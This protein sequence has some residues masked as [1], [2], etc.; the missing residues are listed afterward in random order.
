[1]VKYNKEA[2]ELSDIK[3]IS[4]ILDNFCIGD[5]IS[6]KNG[7]RSCPAMKENEDDR[8]I[9]KVVSIPS[10]QR[11][12]E[13]LLLAGAYPD[14]EAANKYFLEQAQSVISELET[15]NSFTEQDG[16]IPVRQWQLQPM[17]EEE[18]GY[19]VYILTDYG[20]TLKRQFYKEPLTHLNAVNLGIDLCAAL[21]ACRNAGYLYVDLKPTN[22]LV[23][24]GKSFKIGDLGFIKL[25]NIAYASLPERYR[26]AYTAPEVADA[27]SALSANMDVYALGLVLYQ[28]YNNG[29]L[30][31]SDE[32][33]PAQTFE[34]PK[35]ADEEMAEI[36]L[37]ACDPDPA[38]RW[39]D[40]A[41]M[42][43]ALV[44]YMQRVGAND[45]P[46]APAIVAP[47]PVIEE[48]ADTD[49]ALAE[50]AVAADNGEEALISNSE[51]AP[52]QENDFTEELQ[53]S[54]AQLA[55]NDTANNDVDLSVDELIGMID[56]SDNTLP[57]SPETTS[58]AEEIETQITGEDAE[59]SDTPVQA[60]ERFENAEVS[61]EIKSDEE[62]TEADSS[63][64]TMIF[65]ATD[66]DPIPQA[67]EEKQVDDAPRPK[68]KHR[69]IGLL[70]TIVILLGL[71]AGAYCGYKFYYIKTVESIT[72]EGKLDT[73]TVT[74]ETDADPS[75][76]TVYCVGNGSRI[77]A[78]LVNGKATFT[79][80]NPDQR[81]LVELEISGLHGLK[82]KTSATYYTPDQISLADLQI[83][84]GDIDGSANLTFNT[85][86][87]Y[88]GQWKVEYV[89]E[90]EDVQSVNPDSTEIMLK[91]LTIGKTYEITIIPVTGNNWVS[92]N[93][94]TF[95]AQP[96][97]RAQDITVVEYNNGVLNL[98]WSCTEDVASWTVRC[99]NNT[100]YNKTVTVSKLAASFDG[101][102]PSQD[103]TIEVNAEGQSQS[104]TLHLTD[105]ILMVE[106]FT[107]QIVENNF[108]ELNWTC[109]KDIP[110]G[111]WIIE[112]KFSDSQ[113]TYKIDNI[114]ENTCTL[115]D[116]IPGA[117]YEFTIKAAGDAYV[118]A[119]N[120]QVTAPEAEDYVNEYGGTPFGKANI[121][122]KMCVQ[123]TDGIWNTNNLKFTTTFK[124]GE[125][126]GFTTEALAYYNETVDTNVY[127]LYVIR[128]ES[129]KLIMINGQEVTWKSL[130]NEYHGTLSVPA[131][132]ENTGK[133]TLDIY[134]NGGHVTTQAFEIAE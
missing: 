1:M 70:L 34:A 130:F 106:N 7:V 104:E 80:L 123:P 23:T 74:V 119:S 86:K 43:Q 115:K 30:P 46:I 105:T 66:K 116:V 13:A 33:A 47:A 79:N 88:S 114:S 17:D 132:P 78:E 93:T 75:L 110:T 121:R 85:K 108:I 82:G 58:V 2:I 20:R 127:I 39:Q 36:I 68:R 134:Y 87:P 31:F 42:G 89:T 11:K 45:T 14:A 69:W 101:L 97:I 100:D 55:G 124:A 133:Y 94:L 12:L 83:Q 61:E 3:L 10:S 38:N 37:K 4:P 62:N 28:A 63:Q 27:F 26:S 112:Y 5:P 111:G 120:A 41:E 90:G 81:Y 113:E 54:I 103:Y 95:T 72:L 77:P 22:I 44:S 29:E 109:E 125:A 76:L 48:S 25:D 6:D 102:D 131:I 35:Y 84:V 51:D 117:S 56:G 59:P 21:T 19:D 96:V 91:N 73:L 49:V 52:E 92:N 107:A 15:L 126:A 24:P 129:G 50:N 16:F 65:T 128:D 53:L 71:A 57:P 60:D 64:S 122:L 9:L 99:Y 98:E 67:A 8:Y 118:I 32:V 18:T 40:P